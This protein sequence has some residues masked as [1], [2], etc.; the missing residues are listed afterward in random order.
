M[1][2]KFKSANS[3]KIGKKF[4]DKRVQMD[5]SF[6][7]IAEIIYVNKNY[8]IA[9][10]KGEYSIFPSQSFAKAYFKKYAKYLHI[11]CEFPG[12]FEKEI[13]AKN[14]K[15]STKIMFNTFRNMQFPST[16]RLNIWMVSGLTLLLIIIIYFF[17]KNI[18]N[19]EE[20]VLNENSNEYLEINEYQEDITSQNEENYDFMEDSELQK[21][22]FITLSNVLDISAD[23][24]P[25]IN[26]EEKNMLVLEFIDECWVE[27]YIEG[28]LIEAK[29]FKNGD[30]YSKNINSSFSIVVGNADSVKGTYNSED[31]DFI[32]NANRLTR[33]N[34]I[35]F[36]N[37]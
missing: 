32:T 22:D 16:N 36:L 8:L 15:T 2:N 6:D 10:E 34:T 37:D 31:I 14:K 26:S 30:E 3:V 18:S 28:A 25:N 35:N 21:N 13:E 11:D 1:A 12:V 24:P 4:R 29:F 5:L 27:V 17:S 23:I 9:I 7:R 33:V 20:N 19:K